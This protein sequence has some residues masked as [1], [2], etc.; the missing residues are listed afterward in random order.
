[1]TMLKLGTVLVA[2]L[3]CVSATAADNRKSDDA[4]MILSAKP[5]APKITYRIIDNT[6]AYDEASRG[7]HLA[8]KIT[9]PA[10]KG[11]NEAIMIEIYNWTKVNLSLIEFDVTFHNSAGLDLTTHVVG[12]AMLAGYSGIKKI[13]TPGSGPFVAITKVTVSSL[14]VLNDD[15]T[16]VI[17]PTY[18]DLVRVNSGSGVKP[19]KTNAPAK[20]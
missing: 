4:S 7:Q 18:V 1:M 13:A 10:M 5:A 19:V 2:F 15:A 17:A 14:K 9:P 8:F 6:K 12:D 20:K 16:Y 3:Y 11:P